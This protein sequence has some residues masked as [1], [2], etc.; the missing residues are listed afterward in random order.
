MD[1]ARRGPIG[2]SMFERFDKHGDASEGGVFA[3]ELDSLVL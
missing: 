2:G 1:I 3:L